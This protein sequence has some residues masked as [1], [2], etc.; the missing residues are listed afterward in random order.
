M[1]AVSTALAR[2]RNVPVKH[3]VSDLPQHA[4]REDNPPLVLTQHGPLGLMLRD[5]CHS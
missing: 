2:V 1:T 3:L 5:D 4:S